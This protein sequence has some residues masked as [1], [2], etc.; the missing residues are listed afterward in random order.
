MRSGWHG[1]QAQ[2]WQG[3]IGARAAVGDWEPFL[4]LL[5]SQPRSPSLPPTFSL[6]G[7]LIHSVT[8]LLHS[9]ICLLLCV[10]IHPWGSSFIHFFTPSFIHPTNIS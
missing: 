1:A 10:P 5:P 4:A 2:G 3:L 7:G 9:C 6:S 8:S